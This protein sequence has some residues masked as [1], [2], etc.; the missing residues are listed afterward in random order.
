VVLI[1]V[2]NADAGDDAVG[3]VVLAALAAGELPDGVQL[4]RI[5]GDTVALLDAFERASAAAVLID[6][7]RSG[8]APGTIHRAEA[9]T[10]PLPALLRR[11]S[12]TH[13][14]GV[15]EAIELAR[16]TERLPPRV[17]LYGVE[18]AR[19]EAGAGLSGAVAAVVPELVRRVRAEVAA[20]AA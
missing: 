2:G 4:T 8:S 20:P 5:E 17:V 9:G 7:V 19:F 13:A 12:S 18:G 3:L 10:A 16:V 6:A 11:G 15:A 1:G 14:I